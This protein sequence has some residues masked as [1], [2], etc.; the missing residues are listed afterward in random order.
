MSVTNS[1]IR[2]EAVENNRISAIQQFDPV[3]HRAVGL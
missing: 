3:L 1:D 2:S